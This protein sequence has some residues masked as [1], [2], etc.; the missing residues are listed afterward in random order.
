MC[1]LSSESTN[2]KKDLEKEVY[3]L[4]DGRAIS[5]GKARYQAPEILFRPQ[6]IGQE[7]AGVHRTL[8]DSVLTTDMDFR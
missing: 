3:F 2:G 5:I 6:L 8:V 4:P 1:F 7:Y